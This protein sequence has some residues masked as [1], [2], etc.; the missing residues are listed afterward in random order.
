MVLRA[1][2]TLM[3]LRA[4]LSWIMPPGANQVTRFLY[5]F[6]EPIIE[7]IRRALGRFEFFRSCPIDLSFLAT[8]LIIYLADGVIR[9]LF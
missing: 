4:L 5:N 1:V 8:L 3:I 7:P 2:E 9:L 6:T